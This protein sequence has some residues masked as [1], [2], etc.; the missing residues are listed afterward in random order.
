[1]SNVQ[2]SLCITHK[3]FLGKSNLTFKGG[4]HKGEIFNLKLFHFM[5]LKTQVSST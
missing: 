4:K 1:M 2:F 5:G 3:L